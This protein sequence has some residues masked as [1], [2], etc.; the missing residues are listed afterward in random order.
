MF[1]TQVERAESSFVILTL[2][3]CRLIT[4]QNF[5]AARTEGQLLGPST[6][7]GREVSPAAQTGEIL[8]I[9]ETDLQW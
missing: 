6:E 8:R 9:V 4:L 5:R 7:T 3:Q 1:L 2:E